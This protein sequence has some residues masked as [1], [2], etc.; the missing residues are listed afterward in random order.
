MRTSAMALLA[1]FAA[2]P[3]GCS[4]EPLPAASARPWGHA[5]R[6]G[7]VV[8]DRDQQVAYAAD[9]DNHAIFR[10]DLLTAAVVESDLEGAPEQIVLLGDDRLAVTVRDRSE[11]QILAVDASGAAAKV[12]AA[13][14]PAD[15]FGIA[16]SPQGDLLVTSALTHAV[17]ALDV[18]TLEE[19][20]SVD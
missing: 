15:P 17:T 12:A 4:G 7:S 1:L 16:L 13:R 6:G 19:R 2:L 20:W 9:A 11:V 10:V 5:A 8:I 18:D 14:V 3:L